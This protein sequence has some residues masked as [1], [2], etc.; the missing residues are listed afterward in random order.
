MWP[1]PA[2]L[3]RLCETRAEEARGLMLA[4]S[5]NPDAPR[6][7]ATPLGMVSCQ[8]GQSGTHRCIVGESTHG[9]LLRLAALHVLLKRGTCVST[10]CYTPLGCNYKPSPRSGRQESST[11]RECRN[12]REECYSSCRRQIQTAMMLLRSVLNPHAKNIP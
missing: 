11:R 8:R 10:S 6:H 9:R 7:L 1:D 2:C 4:L 5:F 3:P 12:L